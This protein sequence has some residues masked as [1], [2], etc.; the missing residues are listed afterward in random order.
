MQVDMGIRERTACYS[1]VGAVG[2]L[3]EQQPGCDDNNDK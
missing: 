1:G 2:I 3:V